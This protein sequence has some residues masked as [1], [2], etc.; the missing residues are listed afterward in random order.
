V[1]STFHLIGVL[2]CHYDDI[3]E[4]FVKCEVIEVINLRMK[5]KLCNDEERYLTMKMLWTLCNL[6][7]NSIDVFEIILTKE[8]VG[9]I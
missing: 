5:S 8:I 9:R 7:N 4:N 2:C 3:A 6:E 1:S